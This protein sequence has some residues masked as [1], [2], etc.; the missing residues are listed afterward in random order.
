MLIEITGIFSGHCR[1][2]D[3]WWLSGDFITNEFKLPTNYEALSLFKKQAQSP[4]KPL[5]IGNLKKMASLS[6]I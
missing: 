1:I 4:Q 3:L 5:K 6:K 2:V